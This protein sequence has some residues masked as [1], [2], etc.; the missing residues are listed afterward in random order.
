[1]ISRSCLACVIALASS[2]AAS[3]VEPPAPLELPATSPVELSGAGERPPFTPEHGKAS[4]C[5]ASPVDPGVLE[6]ELG[7][8][9]VWTAHL[10][11][12]GLAGGQSSTQALVASAT[13]G[14]APH[15]DVKVASTVAA[16]R[17]PAHLHADGSSPTHGEG[18]GD[19]LVG[20]RWRVLND[21]EHALELA[22]LG[23]AVVPVG[24][25]HTPTQIGL[26]QGFWS[27]RLAL[28]ATK[29]LERFT[30][31]AE[32]SVGAPLSGDAGGLRS[33]FQVNLAAGYHVLPWLQP[34]LELNYQGALGP[35]SQV[36]GF[37]LGV[38]APFGAGQR[39]VAALQHA[40]W[41][42]R[43]AE[44]TGILLAFKTALSG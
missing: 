31:N 43:S 28:V 15:L 4:T 38:V 39:V 41:G 20:A 18:L 21:V 25:R 5:D 24:T 44:T 16:T 3:A 7:Y 12:A 2:G 9:P 29:D 6:L 23:E 37:T 8:A 40:F 35:D 36:L 19:A 1:M 14:V 26:S 34:E 42:Q 32:L 22:L 27:G 30:T 33:I 10:V 11:S 13:Y 17:D